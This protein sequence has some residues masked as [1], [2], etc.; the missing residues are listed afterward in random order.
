MTFSQFKEVQNCKKCTNVLNIYNNIFGIFIWRNIN[1]WYP[2]ISL[3]YIY[4]MF[5]FKYAEFLIINWIFFLF[6]VCVWMYYAYLYNIIALKDTYRF[7]EE[8]QLEQP[9]RIGLKFCIRKARY[10][11][12]WRVV[13]LGI[14]GW[15]FRGWVR[16]RSGVE[17]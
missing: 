6:K 3:I 7:A 9:V 10:Q 11:T 17:S 13:A 5:C 16:G 12:K 15:V 8:Y 1:F 4:E 2:Q 14:A